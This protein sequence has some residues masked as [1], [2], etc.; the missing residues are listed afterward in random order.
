MKSK[1]FSTIAVVSTLLAGQSFATV[2]TLT[3]PTSGGLLAPGFTEA[4]GII[5]DAIGFN[6]NRL[7]TQTAA[8]TLYEGLPYSTPL[9]IGT[10]SGFAGLLGSL[11][12][13]ISQL[14]VRVTLEDGDN[15]T[16]NFDFNDN[17]FLLNG[18][19]IGNWSAVATQTT[20]STGTTGGTTHLGFQNNTL[21]TGWFFSSDPAA[22]ANIF[23]SLAGDTLTYT[24]H[25]VDP[26]DNYYDFTAG[27]DSSLTNVGVPPTVT[28]GNNV[29]DGGSTAGLLG[30]GL[31][32]LAGGRRLKKNAK[33]G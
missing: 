12:G 20:D 15:A 3:S 9:T 22:L 11:G 4:G 21:D 7:T 8:S 10:Q 25:D 18:T 29:P 27:V 14:A 1:L 28:P 30:A 26:G 31:L 19:S 32:A 23:G 2:F 6:G 33:K 5:F 13:G 24:L 17:D 16:G